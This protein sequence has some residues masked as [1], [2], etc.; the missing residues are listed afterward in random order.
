MSIIRRS[1]VVLVTALLAVGAVAGPALAKTDKQIAK[2][3]SIKLADLEGDWT[4]AKGDDD[5][6]GLPEC[7]DIDAID[8]RSKKY[9]FQSPEFSTAESFLSNSV[10]VFPSV[11]QAKAYLAVFQDD[12][13]GACLQAGLE[14]AVADQPGSVVDTGLLD[15]TGGPADDG[16]GYQVDVTSPDGEVLAL[17]AVAFRVGRGVTGITTLNLGASLPET[18]DLAITSIERLRKGLK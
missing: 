10:Y 2:A 6:S 14:E 7:A 8:K 17:Q 16:V 3:A 15:V 12:S 11:K 18:A 9:E 13:A 1:T 5:P 4:A